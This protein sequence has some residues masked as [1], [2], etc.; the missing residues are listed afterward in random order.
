MPSTLEKNMYPVVIGIM[1]YKCHFGMF[2]SP[3]SLLSFAA[4]KKKKKLIM[5]REMLSYLCMIVNFSLLFCQCVC[6]L[7]YVNSYVHI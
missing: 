3:V 7:K 6:L 5:E 1:F 4:F 2:K